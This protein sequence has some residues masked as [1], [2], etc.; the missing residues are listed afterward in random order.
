[1]RQ[2]W[3]SA[4]HARPA[5]SVASRTRP[6]GVVSTSPYGIPAGKLDVEVMVMAG[7]PVATVR[8][9][10]HALDLRV[11]ATPTSRDRTVDLMR[12]LSI[13]VVVL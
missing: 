13:T 5:P 11:A 1:M 2:V 4:I 6:N 7:W 3:C 9:A 12:A 8:A 10:S